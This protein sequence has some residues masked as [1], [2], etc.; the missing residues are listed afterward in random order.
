MMVWG[1]LF[2]TEEIN[3][4]IYILLLWQ[5]S[6]SEARWREFDGI[7]VIIRTKKKLFRVSSSSGYFVPPPQAF[8]EMNSEEAAQNM[9]GY[10]STV[11]PII[12]QQPVFVQFSNHKELKTDNSPNQEVTHVHTHVSTIVL[13]CSSFIPLSPSEGPGGSAGPELVSCGHC[14]AG[15]GSELR[16]EGGGGE[17]A[18]SRLLGRTVPGNIIRVRT[19]AS[20]LQKP[21]CIRDKKT[22]FTLFWSNED[23]KVS[24]KMK[25]LTFYSQC[26]ARS[27]KKLLF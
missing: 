8:L 15:G 27:T 19:G 23:V 18:V 13:R 1:T 2:A 22:F 4:M 3:G 5:R 16:P 12:R 25:F 21:D 14:G 7:V 9:V 26:I 6:N 11:M 17:S 20:H 10:Y 24:H